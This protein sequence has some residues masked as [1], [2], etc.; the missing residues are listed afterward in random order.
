MAGFDRLRLALGWTILFGW[1]ASSIA[2]AFV[3]SYTP[4]DNM[5][6]LMMFLSGALFGPTV[7]GRWRSR[8]D[9]PPSSPAPEDDRA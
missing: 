7:A 6:W 9:S 3:A 1:I 4:P 8:H 5:E 2:D